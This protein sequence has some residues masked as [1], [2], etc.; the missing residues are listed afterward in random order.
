MATLEQVAWIGTGVMGASMCGHLLAA[1]HPVRVSSR[2]RSRAEPLV[3]AGATWCDTPAEAA[4]GA[5]AIFTI[6]GYPA[7]VR[8]VILGAGGALESARR[9]AVLVDMTTSEPSL[10]VEIHAA[11]AA[12]GVAALDA[13]VS[14]GDVGA[15]NAALSIMVGGDAEALERV[16]PLLERMGKTIVH[17]GGP[18]AGQH[19][20]MANQIAIATG[21]IGVC[22]SLL[23]AQRAGLDV[24][25]VLDTIGGGAAGSWSL[26]NYAP[27]MLRGDFEPGFKVDH[28]VKDLGIAIAE[29]RRMR[30]SLPGLALAEQLYVAAQAQGRGD[31]GTHSL[32][33]A[34]AHLSDMEWSAT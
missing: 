4:D 13:P 20:K 12:R 8:N 33:L 6:V 32:V 28:F 3:A 14:G 34:L 11:A 29:S 27:R 18:G 1:G 15:R 9:G 21:M 30:L 16:R 5:D 7:D 2:T 31:R 26:A 17:E 25:R 24:Q 22:E 23:Y 10:A 19:T